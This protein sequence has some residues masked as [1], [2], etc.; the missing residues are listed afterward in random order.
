MQPNQSSLNTII[1]KFFGQG[2]LKCQKMIR[3]FKCGP[4]IRLLLIGSQETTSNHV[5]KEAG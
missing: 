5:K 2:L 4:I 3:I 1:N